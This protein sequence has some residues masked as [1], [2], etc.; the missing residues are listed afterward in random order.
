MHDV[1]PVKVRQGSHNFYEAGFYTAIFNNRNAEAHL[2]FARNYRLSTA[3]LLIGISGGLL[4]ALHDSWTYTYMLK[5]QIQSIG[6]QP[7]EQPVLINL[8]IF[9]ALFCGMLLSAWQRGSLK[10]RWKQAQAWPRHLIGGTLVGVGAVWIPGGNDTLILK[11][12]PGFSPHAIPALVALLC[13]IAVTLLFMRLFTG[14]TLKV[15]CSGDI[16]RTEKRI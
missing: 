1:N 13:G 14:K 16:C 10:L 3:A 4:Y 15:F 9:P 5:N 12:V 8:L 2:L 6:Q 11:S 7:Y